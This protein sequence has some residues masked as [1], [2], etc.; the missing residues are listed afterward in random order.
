MRRFFAFLIV[1]SIQISAQAAEVRYEVSSSPQQVTLTF[2]D[3]K[4]KTLSADE[5]KR[6]EITI[7]KM[8][9]QDEKIYD[10]K[11]EN[12][13]IV[14]SSESPNLISSGI[15]NGLLGSMFTAYAN[16][17]PLTLRPD[18]V[19]LAI[20]TAF[21]HYVET[22][23]EKMRSQFVN[24]SDKE[25]LTVYMNGSLATSSEGFWTTFTTLM[26]EQMQK[27]TKDDLREWLT[28]NFSTTTQKDRLVGQIVMM[29]AMKEYFSYHGV[30]SSALTKLTLQGSLE[31]WVNLRT[32]AE[33][34]AV[35]GDELKAWSENLLPVLDQFVAAYKGD[36]NEDFWQRMITY[37][38]L[39]SGGQKKFRGWFLVFAPFGEEGDYLLNPK[40]QIDE[41]GIYATIL[42]E[43]IFHATVSVPVDLNDNGTRHDLVFWAGVTTPSY[44]SKLNVINPSVD[45][46]II[47]K[48]KLSKAEVLKNFARSYLYSNY[49]EL[50]KEYRT[51]VSKEEFAAAVVAYKN[52][53][54]EILTQE[55]AKRIAEKQAKFDA[56]MKL[57]AKER[58]MQLAE[59]RVYLE[60]KQLEDVYQKA[61]SKE[62]YDEACAQVIAKREAARAA[63]RA[64]RK[65]ESL[66]LSKEKLLIWLVEQYYDDYSKLDPEYQARVTEE[67][68]RTAVEVRK[69][70]QEAR[71]GWQ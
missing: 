48:V 35:Y 54:E 17:I 68:F 40:Q 23:A 37:R 22:H 8:I 43:M 26:L 38:R 44:N 70:E 62:D 71:D 30:L 36:V 55:R 56:F 11:I 14:K 60:Y 29:G 34:L 1:L 12:A 52:E 64:K 47:D 5:V 33:K 2:A 19:W 66:T 18:E 24:H 3:Q 53:Q 63:E 69:K 25:K 7:T 32:R 27:Y 39:G 50:P 45:W 13:V 49:Q 21:A 57:S 20:T 31:D 28:P 9:Q 41:T 61:V 10:K 16:H 67:E 58:A 6:R 42:D 15:D 4:I 51:M 46:A 65:A 59:E